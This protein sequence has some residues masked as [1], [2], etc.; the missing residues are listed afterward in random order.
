MNEIKQ[1]DWLLNYIRHY[2]FDHKAEYKKWKQE[3]EERSVFY[4]SRVTEM[5]QQQL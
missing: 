2:V 1:V 5:G 3:K 4:A